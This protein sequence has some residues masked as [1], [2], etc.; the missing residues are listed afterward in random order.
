MPIHPNTSRLKEL[1]LNAPYEICIERARYYTQSY[2]LTK[3]EHPALRAAKAFAH[4]VRNMTVTILD[5]EIIAGNRSSKLLGVVIPV[6][7]GDVNLILD[8]ELDYLL[9]RGR[10]PFFIDEIDRKELDEEILPWWRNKTVRDHKKALYKKQGLDFSFSKN[11]FVIGQIRKSMDWGRLRKATSVPNATPGYKLRGLKELLHNNPALVMNVFD[12]QGHLVLGHKNILESG[13]CGIRQNALDALN[14]GARTDKDKAAF[15]ES[16]VI[17][18]E[19]VRD[20]AGRFAVLAA[21]KAKK[22]KNPQRAKELEAMASYC[23]HVPYHPQGALPRLLPPS[24]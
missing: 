15:L 14:N 20:F 13:F 7:R 24:G 21:G 8:M 10:Q 4:T 9:K 5:D 19:A 23:A 1:Y 16:V 12:V 6:E 22:E 17:C 11:P 2:K 3:G 18:C